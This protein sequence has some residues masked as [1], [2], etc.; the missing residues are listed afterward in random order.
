MLGQIFE[1]IVAGAVLVIVVMRVLS[2]DGDSAQWWEF[3][4]RGTWRHASR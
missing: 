3:S 4:Y 2:V 1:V